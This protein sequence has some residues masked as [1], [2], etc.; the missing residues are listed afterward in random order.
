M[1]ELV[2]R[3][4]SQS[5]PGVRSEALVRFVLI[6]DRDTV[7][8]SAS[9]LAPFMDDNG[10][11]TAGMR[12]EVPDMLNIEFKT[13]FKFG[14]SLRRRHG[15]GT[16]RHV[17]FDDLNR[18]LYLNIKLPNDDKWSKV[19]PEVARRGLHAR[20]RVSN[21][22]LERRLDITGP[23]VGRPRAVSLSTSAQAMETEESWTGRRSGSLSS[24]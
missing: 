19:A 6:A 24:A 20:E 3:P 1:I 4:K 10:K 23:E 11:A 17:K 2:E 7:M 21:E 18:S 9:C 8:S 12:M 16:R 13:L 5:G 15:P 22:E 14:Q